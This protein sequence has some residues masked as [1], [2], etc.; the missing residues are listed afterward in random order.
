VT[1]MPRHARRMFPLGVFALSIA[2]V[3]SRSIRYIGPSSLDTLPPP[4]SQ[5]QTFLP[6]PIELVHHLW[7][8]GAPDPKYIRYTAIPSRPGGKHFRGCLQLSPSFLVVLFQVKPSLCI[9]HA[10]NKIAKR[11]KIMLTYIMASCTSWIHSPVLT[12]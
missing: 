6:Y 12:V 7:E 5:M 2:S 3:A 1:N 11:L 9:L 4:I 8:N 10:P